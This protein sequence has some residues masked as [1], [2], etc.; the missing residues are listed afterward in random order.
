MAILLGAYVGVFAA[1]KSNITSQVKFLSALLQLPMSHVEGFLPE[2]DASNVVDG[3]DKRKLPE[4]C[5]IA[6][7][8]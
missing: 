1:D 6:L 5:Q 8:A 3:R 2:K 4:S 7:L